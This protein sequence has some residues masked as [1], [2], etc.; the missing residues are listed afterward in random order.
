VRNKEVLNFAA[1]IY[2][3]E[4]RHSGLIRYLMGEMP[5]PRDLE[6]P[7]SLAEATANAAPYLVKDAMTMGT[8][9]G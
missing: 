7:I 1:S 8:T 9:G 4:A 6:K 3:V 5:A 2:G